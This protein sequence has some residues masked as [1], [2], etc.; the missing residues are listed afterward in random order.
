MSE[1]VVKVVSCK[2]R[3]L[4]SNFFHVRE[5]TYYFYMKR[6]AL[7]LK[8]NWNIP[9]KYAHMCVHCTLNCTTRDSD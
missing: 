2:G 3:F 8:Q 4:N 6:N 7:S 5:F 1:D 9:S